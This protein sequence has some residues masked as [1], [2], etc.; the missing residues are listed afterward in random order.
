MRDI[1]LTLIVFGSLPF[2]LKRPW[3][4]VI[5]WVWIS[6]MNPHRLSWGFAYGMPFAM[7][8]AGTTV[9][10]VL[11]NRKKAGCEFSWN[12]TTILMLMFVIWMNV[13][14]IFA[15]H[16]EYAYFRWD[17]VMK[18]F[19]MIFVAMYV[20][21]T[22]KHVEALIWML[23]F[24]IG[25]FSVKGGVFT[26]ATGGNFKVYGPPESD[27]GENN[28]MA[29]ATVMILPLMWYGYVSAKNVW[30]K[31]LMLVSVLMST[32]SALGSHSRG[33]LVAVLGIVGFFWSKG[34][35][36]LVSGIGIVLALP[37]LIA[38]MPD[39]WEKRMLSITDYQMDSSAM[40]R[41]NA[42]TM[43]W[44]LAKD[45]PIVGGGFELYS[46]YVFGIY[47]PDPT[48]VHA[49]H[50]IYFQILGEHGWV[51]FIIYMSM[52]VAVWRTGSYVLRRTKSL[53]DWA[54]AYNLAAMI[55]VSM[56]GWMVGG[57]FLNCGYYDLMFY[58]FAAL[59]VMR[60]LVDRELGVEKRK[61][62]ADMRAQS[63]GPPLAG[64]ATGA[65]RP[66]MPPG[67]APGVAPGVRPDPGIGSAGG[68][69]RLPVAANAPHVGPIK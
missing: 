18:S 58:Q 7:A 30:L 69:R 38:F 36:K 17:K 15:I 20:L 59:V 6:V 5:M 31:R 10:S 32:A 11:I 56:I 55:Q 9:L 45:R 3:I 47:A 25:F 21:Q 42:W 8:V 64:T 40:G 2:I 4:G 65:G 14:L 16:P 13:T 41:I 27:M 37:L 23:V 34:K 44:N 48:D 19:F 39:A 52:L 51:G 63:A 62:F 66:G 1:V 60:R 22:R 24:C 43:A 33:A 57:L 49:A 28:G 35:K 29:L 54:W 53:P 46:P 61:T 26:I 12:S 50:S 68:A 67:V